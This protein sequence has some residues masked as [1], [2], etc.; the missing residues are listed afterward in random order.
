MDRWLKNA[1]GNNPIPEEEYVQGFGTTID[2]E[3]RNHLSSKFL[4]DILTKKDLMDKLDE[5]MLRKIPTHS[6]RIQALSE[7][8]KSTETSSMFFKRVEI[9]Y[10]QADFPTMSWTNLLAHLCLLKIPRLIVTKTYVNLF[11]RNSALV[12]TTRNF[13]FPSLLKRWKE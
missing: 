8:K 1:F 3:F 7:A 5:I 13:S 6:T 11:P 4:E 12:A 9:L 2:E 10:R